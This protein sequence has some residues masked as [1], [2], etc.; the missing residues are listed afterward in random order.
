MEKLALIFPG[1]GYNIDKPLLYYSQRLAKANG[2]NIIPLSYR[3]VPK[4]AFLNIFGNNQK[5]DL[6]CKVALD[7]IEEMLKEEKRLTQGNKI[8]FISKSIGTALATAFAQKHNLQVSHILFTPIEQTFYNP[9]TNAIAFHGT[10]DAWISNELC[11]QKCK[12]QNIPLELIDN[13][14]H[15]LETGDVQNDISN[16]QKIIKKLLPFL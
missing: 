11:I 6:A 8:L 1:I 16:L 5:I 7:H 9:I 12:E 14:N 13:A 2:F 10:N 15:S 4:E 3:T